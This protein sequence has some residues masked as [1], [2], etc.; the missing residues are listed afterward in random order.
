[1]SDFAFVAITK[2]LLLSTGIK[3]QKVIDPLQLEQK[4]DFKIYIQKLK[5]M[6][7]SNIFK[8]KRKVILNLP[9]SPEKSE[10]NNYIESVFQYE[11]IELI[12]GVKNTNYLLNYVKLINLLEQKVNTYC[13]HKDIESL[14][15]AKFVV[16]KESFLAIAIKSKTLLSYQIP[17]IQRQINIHKKLIENLNESTIMYF[18][19]KNTIEDLEYQKTKV[20][21]DSF[22]K[23]GIETNRVVDLS[24]IKQLNK[25]I[26]KLSCKINES[27]RKNL[28]NDLI[29]AQKEAI[30]KM[31]KN[32]LLVNIYKKET[33]FKSMS[34]M[35]LT[36]ISKSLDLINDI[37]KDI[38]F[39]LY[40]INVL[41]VFNIEIPACIEIKTQQEINYKISKKINLAC[42]MAK[43]LL[44]ML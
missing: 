6:I 3:D 28:P 29:S 41:D 38:N 11:M 19:L 18:T 13:F 16:I 7:K 30:N 12:L 22:F 32:Y 17:E 34:N 35:F 44:S 40:I 10:I 14:I 15:Q 2:Q 23:A 9:N 26:D 31:L 37:N 43:K 8:S 5:C 39:K 24:N 1:M 27:I 21:F 33:C 4:K 25:A 36:S 20:F 42:E